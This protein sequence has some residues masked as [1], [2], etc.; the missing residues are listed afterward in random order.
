MVTFLEISPPTKLTKNRCTDLVYLFSQFFVH[1]DE[2]RND[3]IRYCLQQ[4]VNN[5]Y[6]KEIILLNEREYSDEELG[7]TSSKIR[8]V[9]T[10]KR[11]MFSHVFEYVLQEKLQGYV[12]IINIDIFFTPQLNRLQMSDIHE[13][14]KAY[15]LLRHEYRGQDDLKKASLFGSQMSIL[16]NMKEQHKEAYD[17]VI[18]GVNVTKDFFIQGARADSW[19][20]W[21]V[22]TNFMITGQENKAFNFR[23][24]QVGCDNKMIYL[25]KIIGYEIYNDPLWLPIYHYHTEQKRDYTRDDRL[26]DPYGLYIPA[27]TDITRTPGSLGV[28]IQNVLQTTNQLGHLH[29]SNDNTRFG[30]FIK[31]KLDNEQP[32]II[33]RIAGEENNFAFFTRMMVEGKIPQNEQT[34]QLLRYHILKNNAGVNMTSFESAKKYSDAYFKAFEHCELYSVWEPWGAVYRAIQL[35]H[36]Y[37]TTTFQKEKVWAFAFDVYHYLHDPW[38][39]ALR[40]KRLLI[41][42]PFEDSMKEKL[43]KRKEIYG[44]D[45][46]P[47]C[48]FVFIKPPQT[49]GTQESRE[50]DIE[51]RDFYT[52]L[53]EV[54]DD[55]D[56]AL[57]SCGGYGN[58]VCDYIYSEMNKSAIYVG[59]V[60]QMYFGIYGSRWIRERQDIL[61]IHLNE[62][63]SRPTNDEKPKDFQKVEGSCYW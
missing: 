61:R 23:L 36:D 27:R 58:L 8:Q 44:V 12:A 32:F 6:I 13:E 19:D 48:E 47:E 30:K 4:N 59:G 2:K 29:F 35:S 24:G 17:S 43:S 15:A 25:L 40:G 38:T 37:V 20:A 46:F 34:F 21:I 9:V 16:E 3:E 49:Q 50:F 55:F 42:S 14:K 63:W 18:N 22:H 31:E 57:C 33:P 62:H 56:V 45:L 7:V 28:E 52:R 53:D 41:I 11:L 54:K 10:G 60:L 39:W 51:L 26:P 5:S 1:K